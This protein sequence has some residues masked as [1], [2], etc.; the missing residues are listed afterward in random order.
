MSSHVFV[1]RNNSNENYLLA[2]IRELKLKEKEYEVI[3]IRVNNG[4]WIVVPKINSEINE[5]EKV[6]IETK[7]KYIRYTIDGRVKLN[8]EWMN[9]IGAT[10][11]PI[12]GFYQKES[13]PVKQQKSILKTSNAR[14][15]AII[16]IDSR[17]LPIQKKVQEI[18]QEVVIING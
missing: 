14:G 3:E 5:T 10:F 15:G 18:P 6:K 13:L 1:D 16:N 12:S 17:N 9:V 7:N 4:E 8:G 2:Y 11:A